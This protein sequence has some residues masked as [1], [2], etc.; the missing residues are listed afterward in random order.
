MENLQSSSEMKEAYSRYTFRKIIF[1]LASLAAVILLFFVSL[2]I[3][4]LDLSVVDVYDLFIKHVMGTTYEVDDPIW[5][6]DHIV[7]EYRVPR[8]LFAIIAG[9][10]LSISGA[11]MQ[12]VMKNPLADP[13]TTGVSSGAMFGIAVALVL[14]FTVTD[15]TYGGFGVVFNG[16]MFGLIPIVLIVIMA[17]YFRKSPATLILAGVAVSYLFNSI[18]SILLVTTDAATLS[19]VYTKQIGSLTDIGWETIPFTVI[20][21]AIGLSIL[22]P[23]AGKLNLM[24]LDDKVAKSMGLDIETLRLICLCLISVMAAIVISYVGI[25]GFVGLVIPHIVRLL[26][27]SDNKYLIPASATFGAVFLLGCDIISRSI[28]IDAVVPTGVVTSFI[29]APLFMYLIIRN[30]R[31]IW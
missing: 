25:I 8:A 10:S 28:N 29:G 7:W 19:Y 3:G 17:P 30:K 16:I 13:Y 2:C 11:V 20:S 5:F 31:N 26:L 23:L 27:G 21:T 18:T 6:K 12:S 15:S 24:S 9:M 22:L 4:T 1:I 14:G